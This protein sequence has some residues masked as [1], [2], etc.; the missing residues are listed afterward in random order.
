MF[1][2]GV[3]EVVLSMRPTALKSKIS[4][5]D[6]RNASIW[7]HSYIL[8]KVVYRN[9]RCMCIILIANIIWRSGHAKRSSFLL[10]FSFLHP[11]SRRVLTVSY[12][13][14]MRHD[15]FGCAFNRNTFR[16][17]N[18]TFNAQRKSCQGELAER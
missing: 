8:W 11:S 13:T 12:V 6:D 18:H 2:T 3:F 14:T 5:V 7:P 17:P 16:P 10:D 4:S 9:T 1:V 15:R